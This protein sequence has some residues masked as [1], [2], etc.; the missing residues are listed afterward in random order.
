ME[1]K[2]FVIHN[3]DGDTTVREYTKEQLLEDIEENAWGD[4]IPLDAIPENSDTNY[5]GANIL[6]IKGS[7]VTPKAK[8]VVTK[9]DI[10]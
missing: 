9:Y 7:I 3:G 4:A 6:I 5:W 1:D 10:K 2:Y 8:E